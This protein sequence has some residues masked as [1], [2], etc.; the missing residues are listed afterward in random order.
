M[1]RKIIRRNTTQRQLVL[2]E[3]RKCQWHPTASELY[4]IARRQLP[5]ISLGTVYRNLE[6]LA[7]QGVI[8]KVEIPGHE[9]RFDA[10]MDQHY[11]VRCVSCGKVIDM[12]GEVGNIIGQDFGQLGGFDVKGYNLE[13]VGLCPSCK[14]ENAADEEMSEPGK[15][16]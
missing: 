11:H 3:L 9:A 5:T 6:F 13:F 10:Q 7:K 8:H 4:E 14:A 1:S 2:D 15:D 12:K 16:I